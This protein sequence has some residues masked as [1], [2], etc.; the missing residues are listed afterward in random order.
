MMRIFH[1]IIMLLGMIALIQYLRLA[2]QQKS[3]KKKE[4]HSSQ[5]LLHDP[6][7]L[8][9]VIAHLIMVLSAGYMVI[10]DSQNTLM[11]GLFLFVVFSILYGIGKS[12][13]EKQK[14]RI[15]D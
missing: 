15:Q 8:C 9:F 11:Y 3:S 2:W 5:D 14:Y 13:S 6:M 10:V 1:L 12:L 4:E 7:V